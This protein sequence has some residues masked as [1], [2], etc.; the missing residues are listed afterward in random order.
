MWHETFQ[1]CHAHVPSAHLRIAA[2]WL[3]VL[4][5]TSIVFHVDAIEARLFGMRNEMPHGS[6]EQEDPSSRWQ[7]VR[8]TLKTYSV[9]GRGLAWTSSWRNS[10]SSAAIGHPGDSHERALQDLVKRC[11]H[12]NVL[13]FT[14]LLASE[15]WKRGFA[16]DL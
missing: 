4:T 15:K 16:G 2:L 5:I 11:G 13:D 10:K 12:S 6:K 7:Q 9:P 3:G 14:L 8:C 1:F